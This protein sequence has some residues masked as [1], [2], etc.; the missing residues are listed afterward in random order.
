MRQRP[1][2]EVLGA[3]RELGC[4]VISENEFAVRLCR[5][6]TLI[7]VLRKLSPTAVFVQRALIA[8]LDFGEDDYLDALD[9]LE[10]N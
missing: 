4:V 7:A 8:A 5:A 9:R 3:L 2:E 1:W 6:T 10:A